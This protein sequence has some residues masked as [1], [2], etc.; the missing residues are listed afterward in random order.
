MGVGTGTDEDVGDT[1]SY[2]I[3]TGNDDGLFAID[4]SSGLVTVAGVLDHETSGLHSLAVTATDTGSLLAT[5]TVSVTVTDVNEAP[6]IS[7]SSFTVA[8]N[9]PVGVAVGAKT[10]TDEDVGDT[11]SY[12]ITTGNDDGLFAIGASSGLITVAGVLDH[13]TSGLHSLAVT[14]TDTDSASATATMTV[15]VSDVNE[16]PSISASTFTVAENAPVGA[17]VGAKTGT[18]EDAGDTLSY[19]IT[20]GND[21]GLFAIDASSGLVT[22]AGVLDH[23]TSGLHSLAVTATDTGSASST[24]T[25]TVTVSDVNEAPSISASTFTVAENAPVGATVGAKTGTDE[26]AGDTL[27][28]SITTGND[29]GLFAIGASSGLITVAGVLDHET[30]GLHSLAVTATDTGSAS[31]TA[32]MTVTVSDVN[33]AP[34]ISASS[35]TIAENAPVGATVGAK[36]GTDEDAGDTLSYS[37]TTGNDDGLFAIDASSG[38]I[39]VAGVLDHEM[40][41]LHSLSVTVTDTGSLSVAS[42]VSVTVADVNEPPSINASSFTVAENAAVGVAVG[43]GTGT[44]EDAGDTLSYSITSGNDGGLFVIDA[45]HRVSMPRVLRSRRTQRRVLRWVPRSERMRMSGIR[46]VTASHLGTMMDCLRLMRAVV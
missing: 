34:S 22:V 38:L 8:E 41:G 7:A 37:I 20:T 45:S 39:T 27:S 33:E 43:A 29:D 46:L 42:I 4:A 6:S 14:A 2:S 36:T 19:S 5:A 24:A 11:L 18:D 12:S 40:S 13:E 10:G 26:D 23:E 1:L 44:D 16:A 3:T 25:M 9:A 32:T 31:S 30:S 21:D 15:T 28:Y 35:F 17:T